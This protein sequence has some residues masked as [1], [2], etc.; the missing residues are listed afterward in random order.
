[1]KKSKQIFFKLNFFFGKLKF[2]VY[3]KIENNFFQILFFK[4]EKKFFFLRGLLNFCIFFKSS[5]RRF[6]VQLEA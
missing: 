2:F 4:K 6:V 5:K 1:M 3:Q